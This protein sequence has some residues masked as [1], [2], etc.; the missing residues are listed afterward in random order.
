MLQDYTKSLVRFKEHVALLTLKFDTGFA[1]T[2]TRQ[3]FEN[4]LFTVPQIGRW[5]FPIDSATSQVIQLAE[6]STQM[7]TIIQTVQDNLNKTLVEVMQNTTM[8]QD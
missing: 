6:L 3:V 8:V 5:V 7:G 2:G 1:D 4:A